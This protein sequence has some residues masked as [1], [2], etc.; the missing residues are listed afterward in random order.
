LPN[1]YELLGVRPDATT[2]EIRSAYLRLARDRHPDR[3]TDPA[4]KAQAQESFKE[5]TTAF[6]T[7]SNDKSRREYDNERARP[8]ASTPE[9]LASEAYGQGM[10]KYKTRDYQAA[11]ELFRAA[12]H[13]QPNRAEY[14]LALGR[15][16][17]MYPQSGHEAV[18]MLERAAN[19]EPRN[20]IIQVELARILNSQGLRIRAQR[21]A[22][23]ALRLAPHDENVA[24]ALAGIGLRPD[25]KEAAAARSSGILD[26][27][28]GK[29]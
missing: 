19:L 17:A 10:E 4:Q 26:R 9:E 7:L 27:L 2:A 1:Y 8:K 13:H 24:R 25:K 14:Q 21:A 12:V 15:T 23:T 5:I 6:N 18:T 11:L 22:E 16:L 28:R 3:Y 29:S 20:V